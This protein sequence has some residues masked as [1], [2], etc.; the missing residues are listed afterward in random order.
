MRAFEV[1]IVGRLVE[2]QDLRLEEQHGG[3]RD[4]HAPAARERAARA[5]LRRFVEAETGEDLR[6]AR[7]RRVRADVAEALVDG[8]DAVRVGGV[9]GLI[10][11]AGAL[12]VG[13]EHPV[14]DAF[15]RRPAPPA[16]RG[17]CAP[18]APW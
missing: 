1:E 6:R 7:R 16:P 11:Q 8:G 3:E 5:L 4:A 9:L 2:Q 13:G 17:R 15:R 12:G 10:E 14:E 18:S